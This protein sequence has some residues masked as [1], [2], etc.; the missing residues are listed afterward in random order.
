MRIGRIIAW[1]GVVLLAAVLLVGAVGYVLSTRVPQAYA[2]A[3]LDDARQIQVAQEFLAGSV[4]DGF[5][6]RVEEGLPFSWSLR[7]EKCNEILASM[8]EIAYQLDGRGERKKPVEKALREQGISGPAVSF[9][10]GQVTLMVFSEAY[11]RVLSADVGLSLDERGRFRARL[12]GV[13]VGQLPLPASLVREELASLRRSLPRQAAATARP[14]GLI[15]PEDFA[16]VLQQVF[17]ALDD[18]AIDPVL[19]WPGN[20]RHVRIT[21][22]RLAEGEL[23]IHFTPL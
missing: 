10:N 3:E 5:G 15:S 14:D 22:L 7:A 12:E 1:L 2:P 13:R 17:V 6:N 21:G 20:K 11:N 9:Q 23:T 4:I 8:D 18:D 16:R 19:V